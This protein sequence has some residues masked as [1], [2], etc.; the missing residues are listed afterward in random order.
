VARILI[1]E[2]NEANMQLMVYLLRAFGHETFEA[3]EG[4]MGIISSRQERPDLILCDLQMPGMDGYEVA[5]RLRLDPDLKMV[6][7]VAVTAY[8]MAG[9]RERVL[10]AGFNGYISKPINP[11]YFLGQVEAFLPPEKHSRSS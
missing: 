10:S 11:E 1:I 8:A 5:R 7:L 9:D 2:D 4:Q 6:P 3:Q